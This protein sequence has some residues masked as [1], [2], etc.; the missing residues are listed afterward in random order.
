MSRKEIIY[1]LSQNEELKKDLLQELFSQKISKNK[2][3]LFKAL[4]RGIL[5]NVFNYAVIFFSVTSLYNAIITQ[6][7]VEITILM[8]GLVCGLSTLVSVMITDML[9][10]RSPGFNFLK[11]SFL[12]SGVKKDFIKLKYEKPIS[13]AGL[14]ILK[15]YLSSDE[16]KILLA[17]KDNKL[18]YNSFDLQVFQQE[19]EEIL[20]IEQ[21][22]KTSDAL[23][24]NMYKNNN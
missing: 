8:S 22:K 17:D 2:K 12:F 16:M 3:N 11:E 14:N 21:H 15:K 4:G 9:Y 20:K 5:A 10:G 13:L 24:D 19:K 1:N 7:N 18:T 23:V 6:K